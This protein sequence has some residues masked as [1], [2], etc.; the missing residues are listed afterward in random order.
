MR[1]GWLESTGNG[2][3]GQISNSS[4]W[5]WRQ[6][7]SLTASA[8]HPRLRHRPPVPAH[9][10]PSAPGPDRIYVAVASGAMRDATET[11]L[12]VPS[13]LCTVTGWPVASGAA[14]HMPQA[15]SRSL[16]QVAVAV[17]M[18][19]SFA[20]FPAVGAGLSSCADLS[21]GYTGGIS[22]GRC[23]PGQYRITHLVSGAYQEGRQRQ[24]ESSAGSVR[25][26]SPNET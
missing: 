4:W 25:M 11:T 20:G 10:R 21:I 8:W 18:A 24:R 6:Y 17:G 15:P 12:V 23:R 5:H 2:L 1:P 9:D 22:S 3:G 26:L 14:D 7:P 19:G 16:V 13:F